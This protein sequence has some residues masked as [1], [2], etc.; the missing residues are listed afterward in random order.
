MAVCPGPP[1]RIRPHFGAA[2]RLA[3][4]SDLRL[5]SRTTISSRSSTPP[6]QRW[7]FPLTSAARMNMRRP[8]PY[9]PMAASLL[10]G[11]GKVYRM[12][13]DGSSLLGSSTLPG[14]VWVVTADSVGN[15]YAGG[16]TAVTSF[17]G[18]A[19]PFPTTQGAF[20]TNPPPVPVLPGNRGND[21]D[22]HA[23][24]TRFDSQ[25]H[26]LASTLLAG[27]AP[28]MTLALAPDTDGNILAGGTTYSKA[29]PSRGPAQGSFSPATG[30]IA[31]LTPNLSTL[32]WATFA[33]DTRTFTVREVIPSRPGGDGGVF[34][35][36]ATENPPYYFSGGS[37]S[38]LYPADTT[39][40][41]FVVKAAVLPA[42]PRSEERRVGK[43]GRS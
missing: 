9:R 12:S 40:Q 20:Q 43:E 3:L 7:S 22:G 6:A 16:Q 37:F 26:T 35:A 39:F 28:D 4:A 2:I 27:E 21:G 34:F 18:G 31:K 36:G 41:S 15:I 11:G 1:E 29:F 33:G 5:R 19:P 32:Q 24:I 25:F 30:W 8:W 14:T 23:F 10:G 38:G 13:G 17:V 42:A